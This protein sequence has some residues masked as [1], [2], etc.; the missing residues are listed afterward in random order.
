M[1][2]HSSSLNGPGLLRMSSSDSDHAEIVQRACDADEFD[3]GAA[4]IELL[5]QPCGEFCHRCR[6]ACNPQVPGHRS[7]PERPVLTTGL[8]V[9]LARLIASDSKGWR[10]ACS[11]ST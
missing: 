2:S 9:P 3:I 4:Q 6:V 11:F 7:G 1:I 10:L 5:R 8:P